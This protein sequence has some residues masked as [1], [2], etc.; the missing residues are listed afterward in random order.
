MSLLATLKL[1]CLSIKKRLTTLCL[2]IKRY[3]K[4]QKAAIEAVH[5]GWL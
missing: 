3:I 5:Q 4:A 1:G 2:K